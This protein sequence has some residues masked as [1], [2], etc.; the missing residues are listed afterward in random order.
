MVIL[1]TEMR[2]LHVLTFSPF[3]VRHIYIPLLPKMLL[4]LFPQ[5]NAK[6]PLL[7]SIK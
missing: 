5:L 6:N 3:L 7:L 4:V 1:I 2:G